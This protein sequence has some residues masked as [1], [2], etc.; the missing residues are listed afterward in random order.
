GA[1]RE[2]DRDG[3]GRGLG[4]QRR[5]GGGGSGNDG[6][7]P[8]Y[9]LGRERRQAIVLIIRPA[10]FDRDVP[11]L[12]EAGGS[13]STAEA[14]DKGRDAAGRGRAENP[15]RRHGRLLRACRQRPRGRRASEQRNELAAPH[16]ISSSAPAS[17]GEGT[18][19]PSAW[20]VLRLITSSCFTGA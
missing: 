18:S 5:G 15:D 7:P 6:D 16:S 3:R 12:G 19:R 13:K 14:I 2:H 4:G 17:S 11:A 10:I 1:D 9:Q 20:A 8:G